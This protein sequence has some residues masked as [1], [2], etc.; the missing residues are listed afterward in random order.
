MGF[1]DIV[2]SLF[3]LVGVALILSIAVSLGIKVL[4]AMVSEDRRQAWAV[5]SARWHRP[6]DLVQVEE[7]F[8]VA[9][10]HGD[11]PGPVTVRRV[12]LTKPPSYQ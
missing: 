3:A 12:E 4:E 7:Q 1:G 9:D 10:L 11:E 8:S 2:L 5:R 6:H